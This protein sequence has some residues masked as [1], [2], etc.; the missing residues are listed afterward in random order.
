MQNYNHTDIIGKVRHSL[1]NYTQD[2]IRYCLLCRF[3]QRAGEDDLLQGPPDATTLEL[4][5]ETFG[6]HM[7]FC[8]D[9]E[10]HMEEA[11]I[12]LMQ[13]K[14]LAAQDNDCIAFCAN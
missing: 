11:E 4:P 5:N 8:R 13:N 2:H 7:E 14:C 6:V 3:L 9:M 1:K 10:A 12:S